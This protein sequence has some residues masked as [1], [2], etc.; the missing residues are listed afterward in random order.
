MSDRSTRPIG[1]NADEWHLFLC[2]YLDNRATSPNG[3]TFMAVQIADAID[4]AEARPKSL[5]RPA[6]L[7]VGPDMST[8][9]GR[10]KAAESAAW[11]QENLKPFA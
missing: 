8:P 5:L 1:S 10:K 6:T 7:A 3:L 4:A 11:Y 9:E 2:Q